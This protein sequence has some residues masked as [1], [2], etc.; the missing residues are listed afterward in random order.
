MSDLKHLCEASKTLYNLS[1]PYLYES[2]YLSP[3]HGEHDLEEIDT[4]AFR[5]AR[6]RGHLSYARELEITSKFVNLV[7]ERCRHHHGSPYNPSEEGGNGDKIGGL[8]I[9]LLNALEDGKLRS[10]K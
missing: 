4:E 6:D 7:T 10:L 3:S 8:L 2:L 9:P 1:T 5:L